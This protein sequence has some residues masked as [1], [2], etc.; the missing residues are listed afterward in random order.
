MGQL[1]ER[2]KTKILFNLIASSKRFD[3][4]AE[5]I[6]QTSRRGASS[7][8]AFVIGLKCS[9]D[10]IDTHR[11]KGELSNL[12]V[13][14]TN[15]ITNEPLTENSALLKPK[16]KDNNSDRPHSPTTRTCKVG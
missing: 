8:S 16:N 6:K 3:N 9:V 7:N 4:F 15:A 1:D 5:A 12:I 14:I 13:S 10:D 11:E 2:F